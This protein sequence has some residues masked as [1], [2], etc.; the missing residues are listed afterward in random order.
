MH[1][2][3]GVKEEPVE[4]QSQVNLVF[5]LIST[6]QH[7]SLTKTGPKRCEIVNVSNVRKTRNCNASLHSVVCHLLSAAPSWP[8][9]A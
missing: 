4:L 1:L 9:S 5:E 3:T 7:A 6:Q 8:T 2:R